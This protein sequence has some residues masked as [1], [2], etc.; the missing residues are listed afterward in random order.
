MTPFKAIISLAVFSALT[1]TAPVAAQEAST[2]Y[3]QA[4]KEINSETYPSYRILERLMYANKIERPIQIT[5]RSVSEADCDWLKQSDKAAYTKCIL[6][7]GIPDLE[8][9][10]DLTMWAIQVHSASNGI[11]N[12][13]A[14]H[15]G[16][17][18][19]QAALVNNLGLDLSAQACVVA[20]ELA[21][22]QLRHIKTR[23]ELIATLDKETGRKI[24]S[25]VKNAHSK[26]KSN[27]FLAVLAV[28][29]NAASSGINSGYG[30]YSAALNA[31]IANANLLNQ[32][33]RDQEYGPAALNAAMIKVQQSLH[34]Y[35][36]NVI[37]AMSGMQGLPM[38]LVNRTMRDVNSYLNNSTLKIRALSR[39]H[40]LEADAQAV[41]Y[42]AN[43]G[44][45]PS[46]CMRV[47][48]LIHASTGDKT[49]NSEG[50][51]PGENERVG[52]LK[53]ALDRI[54]RSLKSKYMNKFQQYKPLPYTYN[55]KTGIV[56]IYPAN[57]AP[58]RTG[59]QTPA[60]V[61]EDMLGG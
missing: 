10:D 22:I 35:S 14:D 61:V 36:P 23:Q 15:K 25:A 16:L 20:H 47:M 6:A 28:G 40:E 11:I 30:N 49:T 4:K 48:E 44:I 45:D 27:Q 33:A 19:M 12:A 43:A 42:L 7:S 60:S 5:S 57:S 39:E 55:A 50:T 31:D 8:A 2:E 54:P 9:K 21:H 41:T 56:Q 1:G 38:K 37:K 24:S 26:N 3:A 17:I 59:S 34:S 29:L 18:T 13:T 51:H 46:G 52:E 53:K 58:E 32:M